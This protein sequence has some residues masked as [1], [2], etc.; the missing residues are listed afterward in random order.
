MVEHLLPKQRVAGSSPVSRFFF[1]DFSVVTSVV[2]THLDDGYKIRHAVSRGLGVGDLPPSFITH[3][4]IRNALG[5]LAF[6]WLSIAEHWFWSRA[7]LPFRLERAVTR[8]HCIHP[9]SPRLDQTA[10]KGMDAG[11]WSNRVAGCFG[12][13][14][15][16]VLPLS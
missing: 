15:F 7:S 6:H 5:M 16:D 11:K 2:Q 4:I 1:I 8:Y 3:S 13:T 12:M 9:N 14:P 10:V